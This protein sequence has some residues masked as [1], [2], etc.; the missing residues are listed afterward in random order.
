MEVRRAKF[1][2]EWEGLPGNLTSE[3]RAA[4]LR[5][6]YNAMYKLV[7]DADFAKA[8]VDAA[9]RNV[10]EEHKGKPITPLKAYFW[11]RFLDVFSRVQHVL[12]TARAAQLEMKV[13]DL[14]ARLKALEDA[15][16]LK[17]LGTWKS[18]DYAV[19]SFVT[20]AGSVWHCRAPARSEDVPGASA[21]WQLAVKR[22]RDGMGAS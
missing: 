1:P 4:W 14:E 2:P 11:A 9:R 15:P 7:H 12:L 19:G 16:G 13:A 21:C 17:Y 20:K 22:G 8:I 10:N 5:N 18:Q 6:D 3:L